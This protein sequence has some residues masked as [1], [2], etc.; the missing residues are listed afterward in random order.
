MT[1]RNAKHA[2]RY[3]VPAGMTGLAIRVLVLMSAVVISGNSALALP[4]ADDWRD[5]HARC[6][7]AVETGAVLETEGL[8]QR[9][10]QFLWKEV[11]DGLFGTR[12]ERRV[13][14]T[15]A[16]IV[17]TG[18]W[19]RPEGRFEMRLL[20]FPT[21]AGTR[22]ICEIVSARGAPPLA[23]GDAT[24]LVRAFEA[25]WAASVE[26]G[27]YTRQDRDVIGAAMASLRPN[28]RGCQTVSSI[29]YDDGF[30]R[31]SVGEAAGQPDCGGRSLERGRRALQ[32][33]G[34]DR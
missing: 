18:I 34:E 27:R 20:E 1:G 17:P 22:A 9:P 32:M 11:D 6:R 26:Q 31:S 8:R 15:S 2:T 24:R 33:Q 16:R 7:V 23:A 12:F 13:L 14:R 3:R 25:S 21:R 5:L 28:G 29:T 10:P 30:F 19:I 4:L